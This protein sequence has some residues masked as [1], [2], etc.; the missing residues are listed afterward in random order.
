MYYFVYGSNYLK[1]LGRGH[2]AKP[3]HKDE[4][5]GSEVQWLGLVA[6]TGREQVIEP[7]RFHTSCFGFLPLL[8]HQW[9]VSFSKMA[10]KEGSKE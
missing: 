10:T 9:V 1:F 7:T 3:F 6:Q 5:K 4:Y 2:S 8:A